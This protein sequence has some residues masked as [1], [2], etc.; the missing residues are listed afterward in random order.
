MSLFENAGC[1]HFLIIR[2]MTERA[3]FDLPMVRSLFVE[4]V[5]KI[6]VE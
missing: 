6:F 1:P 5:G 2:I 4:V 3:I